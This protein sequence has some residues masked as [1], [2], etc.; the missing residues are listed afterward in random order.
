MSLKIEQ[1]PSYQFQENT[2]QPMPKQGSLSRAIASINIDLRD[3]LQWRKDIQRLDI[4]AKK[5]HLYSM[6]FLE[7][8]ASDSKK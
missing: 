2:S 1:T 8:L 5:T 7:Y 3:E 6:E 4:G